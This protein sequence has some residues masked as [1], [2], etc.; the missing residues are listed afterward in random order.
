MK[1]LKRRSKVLK[2][3]QMLE[4]LHQFD[5]GDMKAVYKTLE[6]LSCRFE[7]VEIVTTDESGQFLC[8]R[9]AKVFDATKLPR[10]HLFSYCL[11]ITSI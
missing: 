11:S 10:K 5:A 3:Q 6:N 1:S 2:D 8:I 9:D 7:I 4:I